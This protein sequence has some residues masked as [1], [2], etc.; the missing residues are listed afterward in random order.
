[1]CAWG[2]EVQAF[3]PGALEGSRSQGGGGQPAGRGPEGSAGPSSES[4]CHDPRCAPSQ[5]TAAPLELAGRAAS[6]GIASSAGRCTALSA[7]T[8]GRARAGSA[9]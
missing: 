9:P 7:G 1:M 2:K 4:P 6:R 5:L 3:L 8:S